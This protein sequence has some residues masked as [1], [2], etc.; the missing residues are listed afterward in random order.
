M[1]PM[2][3]TAAMPKSKRKR[4]LNRQRNKREEIPSAIPGNPES[5]RNEARVKITSQN[6]SSRSFLRFSMFS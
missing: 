6:K 2:V 3:T 4:M 5:S 1:T